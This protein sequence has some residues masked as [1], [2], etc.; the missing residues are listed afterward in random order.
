MLIGVLSACVVSDFG[1]QGVRGLGVLGKWGPNYA[2][3]FV[4]TRPTFDSDDT[5]MERGG[6]RMQTVLLE[7]RTDGYGNFD[8][9][10]GFGAI[11][12][13]FSSSVTPH[14]LRG[15]LCLVPICVSGADWRL[16]SDT[17]T[18]HPSMTHPISSPGSGGG[19]SR[20]SFKRAETSCHSAMTFFSHFFLAISIWSILF[21]FRSL[22]PTPPLVPWRVVYITLLDV[23][24]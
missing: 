22:P 24:C 15:M 1:V 18:I 4:I 7:K 16:Q 19:C 21:F 17:T 3:H 11:L 9:V 12:A 23:L 2:C 14:A 8:I 20:A 10:F 5:P 13:H 6:K